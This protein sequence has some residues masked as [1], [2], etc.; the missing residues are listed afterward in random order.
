MYEQWRVEKRLHGK[1][2]AKNGGK[3]S[4]SERNGVSSR[5]LV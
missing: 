1:I 5:L 2:P 4:D 3:R